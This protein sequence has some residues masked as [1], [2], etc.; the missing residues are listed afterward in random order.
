M[1]EKIH[2]DETLN[3]TA[4]EMTNRLRSRSAKWFTLAKYIPALYKLS[5][6]SS[7]IDEIA[8]ITPAEQSR[9]AVAG[10]VHES[11]RLSG[12]VSPEILQAFDYDGDKLLFPFR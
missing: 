9:W 8:G 7:I 11:L 4:D 2:E 1:N 3:M 6:T 5:Y 12:R 10:T